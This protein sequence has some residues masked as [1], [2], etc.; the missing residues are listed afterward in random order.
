[1]TQLE[2]Y[3]H[4]FNSRY[5]RNSLPECRVVWRDLSKDGLM[6][7]YYN[8][9][10]TKTC[11]KTGKPIQETVHTIEIAKEYKTARRV[12]ALVLLHEMVHLKL[13]GKDAGDG[14]GHKFQREMKRLA[15]LGAFN[16]L[17]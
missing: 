3:F 14:H 11:A 12:W 7:S 17:W 8:D 2:E 15:T 9:E 10:K 16:G 13:N 1:V 4:L 6:G 5:F